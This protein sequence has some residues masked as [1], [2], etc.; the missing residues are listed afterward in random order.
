MAESVITYALKGRLLMS[1]SGWLTL[2]VPN[3]LGNG[4]FAALAEPGVEQPI[5]ETHNRYN[6]H[7]SVM[8]PEEVE[9]IGGSGVI[10]ERGR[11][12]GFNLSTVREITNPSGWS[13]VAKVW[14]VEV[15]SPEL[16]TLRR[17]YGLGEPKYPFH[18]TFAIRKRN[19]LRAN[20]V[21]A[22]QDKTAATTTAV[23]ESAIHG[24]G[25][26]AMRNFADGDTVVESFMTQCPN[27]KDGHPVFAQSEQCRYTN[28]ADKPNAE[29][30][31]DGE[32]VKLVALRNI[33]ANEE[34]T[35]DYRT[36][37][38]VLGRNV[39]FRYLGRKYDGSATDWT[40]TKEASNVPEAVIAI[41]HELL[42]GEDKSA[43]N[44]NRLEIM[45]KRRGE[46]PG[47]GNTF[48][49]DEP[50][51]DVT[52]CEVC[53]RYG[54]PKQA[55]VVEDIAA[56][57]EATAAP[58][59]QAIA[60]AGNYPKGKFSMHG[61]LFTLETPKGVTRSGVSSNG[62]KW[63]NTMTADYGYINRTVGKDGDHVDVFV[64]PH[65]ESEVVFVVDQLTPETGRFDEHKVIFGH[66]T[67][68][69]AKACYLS[70]YSKDWKGM[71]TVTSLTIPQFKWW[72][73]NGDTTKPVEAAKI[74]VAAAVDWLQTSLA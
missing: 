48:A 35:A 39:Q 65:P 16:M 62:K 14:L 41:V 43:V 52:M 53:E 51:P 13:D 45:R 63:S 74:K 12:F 60:A 11:T 55:G 9:Q 37:G 17:T 59:S 72:L 2:E 5:S 24:R 28:H 22:L 61:L 10:T 56:A 34:V 3:D 18:I 6:A 66:T 8:R 49:P 33:T 7:V 57:R 30:V 44:N 15:R 54:K 71:G 1:A 40:Q 46:C 58:A 50:Y 31:R 64:G 38:P 23:R 42:T 27:D 20:A 47:C 4:L 32:Y 69:D 73:A 21:A 26:F 19:A 68:E 29:L 36:C 67:M 25:L 70:N